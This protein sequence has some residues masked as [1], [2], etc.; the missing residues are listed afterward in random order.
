MTLEGLVLF[1]ASWLGGEPLVE[2][3]V[4]PFDSGEF[5]KGLVQDIALMFFR[6]LTAPS[7]Q[8]RLADGRRVVRFPEPGGGTLDITEVTEGNASWAL[9]LRDPGGCPTRS[10]LYR[11]PE[12]RPPEEPPLF[13][14]VLTLTTG[15]PRG[16]A[17]TLTLLEAHVHSEPKP[18]R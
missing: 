6:P 9:D 8:G 17:L 15:G 4:P 7:E 16:Y 18:N 10:V 2:R 5:A 11:F 3:S 13:P 12:T 1:Q 14:S